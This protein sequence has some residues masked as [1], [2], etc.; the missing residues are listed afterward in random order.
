V[1]NRISPNRPFSFGS[2]MKKCWHQYSMLFQDRTQNFRSEE[3]LAP[4]RSFTTTSPTSNFKQHHDT[5]TG[6]GQTQDR[7]NDS[8]RIQSAPT[9]CDQQSG[10]EYV[11]AHERASA[12]T[13]AHSNW[14]HQLR[15]HT[16][17]NGPQYESLQFNR[18]I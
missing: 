11:Q 12:T 7:T 1:P 18:V 5:T 16:L 17:L 9:S 13:D 15:Q 3:I 14:L 4:A 8:Y 10:H 6:F 2:S